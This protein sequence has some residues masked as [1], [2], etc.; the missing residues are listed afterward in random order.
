MAWSADFKKR[1][2]EEL[3]NMKLKDRMN[4][5]MCSEYQYIL[6][7]IADPTMT[8]N[9]S[10]DYKLKTKHHRRRYARQHHFMQ[11]KMA[12]LKTK[13]MQSRS[14]VVKPHKAYQN[15]PTNDGP[16]GDT[17]DDSWKYAKKDDPVNNEQNESKHAQDTLKNTKKEYSVKV[18]SFRPKG[19]FAER[20]RD[21]FASQLSLDYDA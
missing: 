17:G 5:H 6:N 13:N 21:L 3:N 12:N 20:F 9:F 14:G 1:R 2:F 7:G 16:F 8:T 10:D 4:Y 19:S 11:T 15:Y 18:S